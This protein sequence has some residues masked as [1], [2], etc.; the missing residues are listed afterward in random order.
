MTLMM[1]SHDERHFVRLPMVRGIAWGNL[2]VRGDT[3]VGSTNRTECMSNTN[4]DPLKNQV[5]K[6]KLVALGNSALH[7]AWPNGDESARLRCMGLCVFATAAR[8]V[9]ARAAITHCRPQRSISYEH[10]DRYF[11]RRCPML[12]ESANGSS[13]PLRWCFGPPWGCTR[14]C[15]AALTCDIRCRTASIR[16]NRTFFFSFLPCVLKFSTSTGNA[17]WWCFLN[18]N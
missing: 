14:S 7:D 1:V 5:V 10:L 2:E 9:E 16:H 4:K 8:F 15:G 18:L 13:G 17:L 3:N 11:W 6:A 12:F